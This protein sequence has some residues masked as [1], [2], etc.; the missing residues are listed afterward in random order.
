MPQLPLDSLP[1]NEFGVVF[2]FADYAR[3]HGLRIKSIRAAYPDCVAVRRNASGEREIRIE[4]EFSSINFARHRH[5]PRKADWLV[6]WKHDWPEAPQNLKVIELSR[7][8]GYGFNVWEQ[9]A[10][11]YSDPA[12]LTRQIARSI[13]VDRRIRK[14]DVVV[15]G[16]LW[17]RED[18]KLGLPYGS[19]FIYGI[20]RVIS[21]PV[22]GCVDL[23][24]LC[25][26]DPPLD[27]HDLY[28]HSMIRR[29]NDRKCL[30]E[31]WPE[32]RRL[33]IERRPQCR[34]A[35]ERLPT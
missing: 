27:R 13:Q 4:F 32:L 7:Y 19:F 30:T 2:L 34:S 22:K 26:Y 16:H 31:I 33:L 1:N 3:R 17:N 25:S 23:R 10:T 15:F 28:N 12:L 20:H 11:R 18:E 29:H 9:H 24:R 35:L 6:C 5:D 21:D 8:Y 14:G